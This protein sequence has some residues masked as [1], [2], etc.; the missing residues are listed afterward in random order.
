[1]LNYCEEE[2]QKIGV[3]IELTISQ[4]R[5]VSCVNSLRITWRTPFETVEVD[6]G[7]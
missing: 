1:M 2:V 5:V 4:N 3:M 7:K 6:L